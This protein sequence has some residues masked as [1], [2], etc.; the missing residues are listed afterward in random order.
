MKKQIF[1]NVVNELTHNPVW[2][3]PFRLGNWAG[4]LRPE[5]VSEA[6]NDEAIRR[7]TDALFEYDERI[8][9]NLGAAVP[10]RACGSA[11]WGICRGDA[12]FNRCNH[13]TYD[14]YVFLTSAWKY[15]RADYPLLV[16]FSA[17]GAEANFLLGDTYGAGEALLLVAVV[18]AN[19]SI[20]VPR[21]EPFKG[22][23]CVVCLT[24]QMALRQLI[25]TGTP[26]PDEFT[27]SVFAYDTC[28][29]KAD[30]DMSVLITSVVRR[31]L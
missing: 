31:S 13:G 14:A 20:L 19:L 12:H 6:S 10:N 3:M 17:S 9:K 7:Q 30:E 16:R 15:S 1:T 21:V 27:L 22:K 4:G 18:E 5:L 26:A 24:S 23:P 28:G 29:G 8:T 11:T 2:D 25:L